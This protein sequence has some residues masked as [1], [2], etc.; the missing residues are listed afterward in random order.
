QEAERAA[1]KKGRSYRIPRQGAGTIL[2]IGAPNSG[3][4]RILK[5]LTNAEP[6]VADYPFSTHEQMP[7][8]MPWED[9]F[10]QLVDTPP[11][12]A[13]HI[14]PYLVNMVR[15]ADG[16]VLCLDGSSDDA[17]EETAAVVEQ[18]TSRKTELSGASGFGDDDFSI[19]RI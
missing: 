16:V 10:V 18:F 7:G 11:I 2:L 8:M 14:E 15:S 17:P 9:V 12:T 6:A 3:K 1:P 5:E 4:S 19:V 13:N